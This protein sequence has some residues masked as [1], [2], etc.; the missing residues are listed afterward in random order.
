[1]V[2]C[3][4]A[5]CSSAADQLACEK[6]TPGGGLLRANGCNDIAKKCSSQAKCVADS[7]VLPINALDFYRFFCRDLPLRAALTG[8]PQHPSSKQAAVVQDLAR[9]QNVSCPAHP[10]YQGQGS[11]GDPDHQQVA[12][13]LESTFAAPSFEPPKRR[14]S[15][16]LRGSDHTAGL[17]ALINRCSDSCG[18]WADFCIKHDANH[19]PTPQRKLPHRAANLQ[20]RRSQ[21][22]AIFGDNNVAR[23]IAKDPLLLTYT[24]VKLKQ[25]MAQLQALLGK[26]EASAM[27]TRMPAL[28]HYQT[29][30]L[31]RKLDDLYD[32]LPDADVGKV[33]QYYIA[34][35]YPLQHVSI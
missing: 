9:R 22:Q 14:S 28:L 35:V 6:A 3:S 23:A 31:S 19:A 21:L 12:V 13:Q 30:T 25:D 5:A 17:D 10:A 2:V 29:S 33:Q 18:S 27:V 15:A 4:S 20:A 11:S 32:L 16:S 8:S 1:M 34:L 7:V 24:P 26:H